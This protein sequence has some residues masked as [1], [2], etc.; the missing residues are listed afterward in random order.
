MHTVFKNP[1][2]NRGVFLLL[3]AFLFVQTSFGQLLPVRV[4]SDHHLLET[5]DGKPFFWLGDTGWELF[6]QL[7]RDDATAYFRKRAGQGFT[8]IQAV[9][10]PELDGLRTPNANGELPF[11]DAGVSQPNEQYFAYIDSLIDGAAS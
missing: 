10:L 9:A 3:A 1:A 7:N 11:T 6:H 2:N 5:S 4:S 8:V